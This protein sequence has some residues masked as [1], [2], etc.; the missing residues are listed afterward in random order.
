MEKTETK[1]AEQKVEEEFTKEDY[2]L[3]SEC[4]SMTVSS[5]GTKNPQATVTLLELDAKVKSKI[6]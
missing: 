6:K 2:L 1:K 5:L 4:L 3:I